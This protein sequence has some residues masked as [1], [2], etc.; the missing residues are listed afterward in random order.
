MAGAKQIQ[1]LHAQVTL[2][3]T[4]VQY[5]NNKSDEQAQTIASMHDYDQMKNTIIQMQQGSTS[6]GGGTG[7]D[8][9][10]YLVNIKDVKI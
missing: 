4:Q 5:L 7:G 3:T 10:K 2:L 9:T 8:A 1:Q 6:A